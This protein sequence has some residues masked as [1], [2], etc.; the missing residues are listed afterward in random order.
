M[1]SAPSHS[2]RGPTD[3]EKPTADKEREAIEKTQQKQ[4]LKNRQVEFVWFSLVHV[5]TKW[6]HM[7]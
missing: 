1:W 2:N 3:Y 7:T 5:E 4:G 6:K